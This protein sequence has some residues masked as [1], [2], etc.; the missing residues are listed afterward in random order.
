MCWQFGPRKLVG[1]PLVIPNALFPFLPFIKSLLW[2]WL[3]FGGHS[4]LEEVQSLTWIRLAQQK[5][6]R[7]FGC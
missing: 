5:T 1:N 3:I 4:R 2:L 6:F 7:M